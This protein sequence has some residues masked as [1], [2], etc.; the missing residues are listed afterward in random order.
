VPAA[1]P[2]LMLVGTDTGVGKTTV[3]TAL[4]VAWRARGRRIAP[5]KPA[6]SGCGRDGAGALVPLDAIQLADAA[7]CADQLDDVC[8]YRYEAPLAP[9]VAARA[10]GR[11][12]ELAGVLAARTRLAERHPHELL[13]IEGAGGLLV[14]YRDHLLGAD[15]ALALRA[16]V[17]IV[18]RAGLGT[19]NHTALSIEAARAR[20]LEVIGVVLS[21][22]ARPGDP[23]EPSNPGEI[24]RLTGAPVF[25]TLPHVAPFAPDAAGR[26]LATAVDVERIWSLAV[27]PW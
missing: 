6:E 22:T 3:G 18:A 26:A 13:L 23:S 15:V 19:I 12:V 9:G 21:R 11:P 8:P 4:I 10:E 5:L 17:L 2:A 16:R 7:G 27:A 25:G 20:G 14:P 1:T 24:E